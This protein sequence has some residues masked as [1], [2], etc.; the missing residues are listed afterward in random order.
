MK[1]LR[2]FLPPLLSTI[3]AIQPALAGQFIISGAGSGASHSIKGEAAAPKVGSLVHPNLFMVF[4]EDDVLVE[5]RPVGGDKV[6]L[7]AGGFFGV[8]IITGEN[9]ENRIQG[10]CLFNSGEQLPAVIGEDNALTDQITTKDGRTLEGRII[11]ASH[12]KITIGTSKG[13]VLLFSNDIKSVVSSRVYAFT[14]LCFPSEGTNIE[15]SADF[16]AKI[17]RFELDQTR[18]EFMTVAGRKKLEAAI[19][20]REYTKKQKA[21]LVGASILLTAAAIALPV[22]LAVPLAGRNRKDKQEGGDNNDQ[23]QQQNDEDNDV[24]NQILH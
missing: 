13:P 4:D 22:A 9:G 19:S 23:G 17:I 15:E 2:L 14:G 18:D 8:K 3:L 10:Y 24:L 11:K 7:L 21:L 1:F 12:D 5:K 6:T 16:K 20:T